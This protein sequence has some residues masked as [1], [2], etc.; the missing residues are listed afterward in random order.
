MASAYSS[1]VAHI[2]I[3]YLAIADVFDVSLYQLDRP[4]AVTGR[5]QPFL[6]TW[7]IADSE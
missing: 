1:T 3:L 2:S 6:L 5:N 4:F 7:T